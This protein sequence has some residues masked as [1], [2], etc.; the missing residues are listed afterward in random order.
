M[1]VWHKYSLTEKTLARNRY[2]NNMEKNKS[3]CFQIIAA[4]SFPFSFSYYGNLS[5]KGLPKKL[6]SIISQNSNFKKPKTE[7]ET[8]II[9]VKN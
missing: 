2:L 7:N 8:H 4:E 5:K 3:A 1:G 9:L 6:M